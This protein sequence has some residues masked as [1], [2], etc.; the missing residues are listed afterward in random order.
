[1]DDD[2]Q[3]P[4][5]EICKLLCKLAK[6]YDVVYGV[7]KEGQH[8]FLR[9]A[10]AKMTKMALKGALGAET[11]GK[12]SPF[13]AFRTKLRDAFADY[14]SSFVSVDVLLT[15]GGGAVSVRYDRRRSG[16]SQYTLRKLITHALNMMTGFSILPLQSGLRCYAIRSFG[17][18]FCG[19][20]D[21]SCMELMYRDSRFW[22]RSSL[23]FQ[24]LSYLPWAFLESISPGFILG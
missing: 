11:A 3:H 14:Q 20:A 1:M 13:R 8:G 12:V 24:E 2:L 4:P 19:W 10:A 21:I 6:G 22:L 16:K 23:S 15:W 17:A 18:C 9:N 7:P 5:G